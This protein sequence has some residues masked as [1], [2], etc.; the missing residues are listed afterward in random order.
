MHSNRLH[1]APPLS[2][3]S[4]SFALCTSTAQARIYDTLFKSEDPN[5]HEDWLS[6]INPESLVVL[7]GC[8][9][10]PALAS[11][12]PGDCFQFERLG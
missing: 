4:L 10:N 12:K 9:A 7:Q 8:Y 11:A 2:Q 5:V 3:L 6:D 1:A